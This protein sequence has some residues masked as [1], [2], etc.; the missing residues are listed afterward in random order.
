MSDNAGATPPLVLDRDGQDLRL[1]VEKAK[2]REAIAKAHMGALTAALP[3]VTDAPKGEVA[4]GEKAGAFGPWRAHQVVDEIAQEIATAAGRAFVAC[5]QPRVLVVNDRAV[6]AGDWTSRHVRSS[7]DRQMG[8]LG[9]LLDYVSARLRDLE[10]AVPEDRDSGDREFAEAAKEPAAATAE[11]GQEP[12]EPAA[13][14]EAVGVNLLGLLR[15][16][17]TITATAV[18]TGPTELA[19]LTAAHLAAPARP[20]GAEPATAR[21]YAGAQ[22]P[23]P[24]VVVYADDFSTV[25]D[26]PIAALFADVLERRDAAAQRLSEMRARLAAVEAELTLINARRQSLEQSWAKAVVESAKDQNGLDELRSTVDKLFQQATSLERAAGP[27]REVVAHAQQAIA[28]VDASLAALVTAPAGGQSPM[29]TAVRWE[30]VAAA[31]EAENVSHVLYVSLDAIGADAVTR[32]SI[33]GTSGLIR[34]LGAGNA[35]WLLMDTDGGSVVAGGQASAAGIMTFDL[36][37]GAATCAKLSDP[38]GGDPLRWR[39][40]IVTVLVVMLTLALTAA[41]VVLGGI[42]PLAVIW[43]WGK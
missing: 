42:W 8:R 33:L 37:K 43:N 14:A 12:A 26:S 30:R 31:A 10:E 20:E 25:G 16:D 6:L 38:L 11:A 22:P 9:A 24:E 34:F 35:S 21:G 15:T 27:A 39:E 28:D 18:S 13:A 17:Y 5:S 23:R 19:T 29:L 3:A 40:R 2:Y 41:G 32:R 36:Q 1:E 7:L 4:L